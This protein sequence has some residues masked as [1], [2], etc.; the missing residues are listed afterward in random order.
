MAPVAAFFATY[1]A[2][3]STVTAVAAAGYQANVASQG[4]R[5]VRKA[6]ERKEAS[7]FQAGKQR[8][9]ARRTQEGILSQRKKERRGAE[10][11][12]STIVAGKAQSLGGSGTGGKSL[13]G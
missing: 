7:L 12:G 4:R 3:I 2:A 6:R 11:F 1:G 13:L 9:Q 10:G 8:E 5:D